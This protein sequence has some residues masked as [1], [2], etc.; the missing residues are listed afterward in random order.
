MTT[1]CRYC[2]KFRTSGKRS[3]IKI[4]DEWAHLR[5]CVQIGRYIQRSHEVCGSFAP[6]KFFHCPTNRYWVTP[7]VCLNRQYK[8]EDKCV[9]CPEGEDILHIMR[10]HRP[11][12]KKLI[13][14]RRKDAN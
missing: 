3:E 1:K 8:K 5:W 10:G 12:N 7:L 13:T 2:E 6:I 14:R 9:V 4:G 11:S